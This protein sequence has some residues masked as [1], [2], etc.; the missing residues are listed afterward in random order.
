M[1]QVSHNV[2]IIYL[3]VLCL[4]STRFYLCEM[5]SAILMF[6]VQMQA[7]YGNHIVFLGQ[8][9][10]RCTDNCSTLKG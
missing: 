2:E 5:L 6:T 3:Y 9:K 1:R 10:V 4:V 8:G 7:K